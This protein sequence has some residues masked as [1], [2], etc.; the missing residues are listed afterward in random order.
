MRRKQDLMLPPLAMSGKPSEM[1]VEST[2]NMTPTTPPLRRR[3]LEPRQHRE[4]YLPRIPPETP[5]TKTKT[6]TREVQ[7]KNLTKSE[8]PTGTPDLPTSPFI[9]HR[10]TPEDEDADSPTP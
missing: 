5:P 3:T 8:A 10:A 1:S 9:L 7:Q 2:P 6:K 4:T